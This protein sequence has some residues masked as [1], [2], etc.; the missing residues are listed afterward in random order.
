MVQMHMARCSNCEADISDWARRIEE[1]NEPPNT[2]KV[3]TCPDCDVVL[4]I[5]DWGPQAE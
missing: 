2:P 1:A 4:G 3:W 5:S